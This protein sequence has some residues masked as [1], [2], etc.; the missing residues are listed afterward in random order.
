MP[1]MSS[2]RTMVVVEFR[3]SYPAVL[4]EELEKAI[5]FVLGCVSKHYGDLK[6]C[7]SHCIESRMYLLKV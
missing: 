2:T 7:F 6:T 5:G 4:L 1:R 3:G